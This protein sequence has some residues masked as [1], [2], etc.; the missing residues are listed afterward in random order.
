MKLY[1][2]MGLRIVSVLLCIACCLLMVLPMSAKG[3]EHTDAA[4]YT[5]KVYYSPKQDSFMIGQLEDGMKL[6]VLGQV[7]S[8]YKID[9]YDMVGYIPKSQVQ[10]ASEEYYVNCQKDSVH[11]QTIAYVSLEDALSYR[12]GVLQTA[13]GKLGKPYV[14]GCKG[15]NAFDCSGYTSYV[16]AQHGFSLMR[17]SQ[18][19]LEDGIIIS[20]DSLQ[21]G[22]LL[23]Y[24]GTHSR[25]YV[26]HVAMYA[27]DGKIIHADSRGVVCTD[28]DESYYAQRFVCARRVINADAA[29]IV[30]F[31]V[32]SAQNAMMRS[33]DTNL[34]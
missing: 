5:S 25:S 22:D 17:G 2:N 8:F 15:P 23:F 10:M 16:Y 32:P 9:C 26:S 18:A 13:K 19:Q 6:T 28:M 29:Q 27:G 12:A 34:R 4:N 24:C 21:V 14:Y 1:A 30:Q 7:G 11:T 33:M 20:A 31:A 3:N